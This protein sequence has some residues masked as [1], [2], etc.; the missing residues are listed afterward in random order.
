MNSENEPET[1]VIPDGQR[2]AGIY[3]HKDVYI[4]GLGFYLAPIKE[5]Q[6]RKLAVYGNYNGGT[7][8]E[9]VA[10]NSSAHLSRVEGKEGE[11]INKIKIEMTNGEASLFNGGY[12]G[13]AFN[14]LIPAG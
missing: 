10:R 3:G 5:R 12:D 2:L 8:F 9:W 13:K 4:R 14:H 6:T 7:K 11:N 1:Y